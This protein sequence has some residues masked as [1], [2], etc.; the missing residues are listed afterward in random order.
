MQ[1]VTPQMA[2]FIRSQ[3]KTPQVFVRVLMPSPDGSI[4]IAGTLIPNVTSVHI[5]RNETTSSDACDF[6]CNDDNFIMSSLRSSSLYGAAFDPGDID[7]KF[8]VYLG[9]QGSIP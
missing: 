4:T 9:F 5:S 6:T 2:T 1:A 7:K 8:Q 3:I